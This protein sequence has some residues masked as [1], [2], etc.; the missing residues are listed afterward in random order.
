MAEKLT[1]ACCLGCH[2]NYEERVL[3]PK[4]PA[5]IRTELGL[6][7]ISLRVPNPPLHQLKAHAEKEMRYFRLY[8]SEE[9]VEQCEVDHKALA[10]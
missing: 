2:F 8:C 9:E 3:F 7:H 1:P 5:G 4:L 6:E 10:H